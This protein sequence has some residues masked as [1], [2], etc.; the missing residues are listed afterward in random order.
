MI[1][2]NMVQKILCKHRHVNTTTGALFETYKLFS[3]VVHVA[4][5]FEVKNLR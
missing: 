4:Q 3:Q 1:P 2:R 5:S